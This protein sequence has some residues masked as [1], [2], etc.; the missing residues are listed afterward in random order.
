MGT[1]PY[2]I[3]RNVCEISV[4]PT[5]ITGPVRE[6]LDRFSVARLVQLRRAIEAPKAPKGESREEI[7]AAD[8]SFD[9]TQSRGFTALVSGD[10]IAGLSI[11]PALLQ[12]SSEKELLA[13]DSALLSNIL[14]ASK[15]PETPVGR[16]PELAFTTPPA[17]RETPPPI[18]LFFPVSA[19]LKRTIAD[20][21][22]PKDEAIKLKLD[23]IQLLAGHKTSA[24]AP[25]KKKGKVVVRLAGEALILRLELPGD[26]KGLIGLT[27]PFLTPKELLHLDK[28][29]SQLVF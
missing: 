19:I 16:G 28:K 13:L 29:L 7:L 2:R 25:L 24:K 27:L 4:S 26:P 17:E 3:R 15:R 12:A 6:Q 23:V 21:A 14:K 8:V 20:L 11:L 18:P 1:T 5:A 10:R 22:M 9:L